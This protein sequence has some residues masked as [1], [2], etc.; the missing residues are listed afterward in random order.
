VFPASPTRRIPK[1]IQT[2]SIDDRAN[3]S[4]QWAELVRP[5]RL[6]ARPLL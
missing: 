6:K 1:L 2:L 5:A 3:P 4:Q